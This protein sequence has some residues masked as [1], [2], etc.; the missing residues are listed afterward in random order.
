MAW[1]VVSHLLEMLRR[2]SLGN[3][4][5]PGDQVSRFTFLWQNCSACSQVIHLQENKTDHA[6]RKWTPRSLRPDTN[7][8]FC[9]PGQQLLPNVDII[10]RQPPEQ[11]FLDNAVM[12]S[13]DA[14]FPFRLNGW[15]VHEY[16]PESVLQYVSDSGRFFNNP[17]TIPEASRGLSTALKPAVEIFSLF[18][19]TTFS[20]TFS[21]AALCQHRI[22]DSLRSSLLPSFDLQWHDPAGVSKGH[23]S[24]TAC[25]A[26]ILIPHY[27][28]GMGVGP[29]KVIWLASANSAKWHFHWGSHNRDGWRQQHSSGI[30]MIF[31]Y[32]DRTLALLPGRQ[33][34]P[35]RFRT[36]GEWRS[37]SE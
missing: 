1:R 8:A 34:K 10:H 16:P 19:D 27:P 14:A 13:L 24:I 4:D 9:G 15:Y 6:H 32:S 3:L 37:A 31:H 28:N 30:S 17:R 18:H 12:S 7:Q 22:S 29:I 2:S 26:V 36:C 21:A 33:D 5:L 20:S 35:H 11:W 25:L 23:Q